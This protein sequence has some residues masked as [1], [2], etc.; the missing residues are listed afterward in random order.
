MTGA[1]NGTAFA[2]EKV[3]TGQPPRPD[4]TPALAGSPPWMAR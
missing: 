4:V 2:A 1:G 3:T